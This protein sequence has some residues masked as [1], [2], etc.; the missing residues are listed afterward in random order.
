[1]KRGL[2]LG[3]AAQ[4]DAGPFRRSRSK[5]RP[6][7]RHLELVDPGIT[8][9]HGLILLRRRHHAALELGARDHLAHRQRRGDPGEENQQAAEEGHADDREAADGE[10]AF[11]EGRTTGACTIRAGNDTDSAP[12]HRVPH[13][14]CLHAG[15]YWLHSKG[16]IPTGYPRRHAVTAWHVSC[17]AWATGTS[18][19]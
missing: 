14:V 1:M 4:P 2:S 13:L 6:L 19:K 12:G 11:A 10:Y 18:R 17:Q 16:C 5:L 3:V 7:R 8:H 9:P 15:H